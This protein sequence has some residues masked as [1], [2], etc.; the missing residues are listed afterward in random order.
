MVNAVTFHQLNKVP[1]AVALER[2]F[3]E[4]RIGG[5][6]V[7]RGG[8]QVGEIAATAAGH[9]DFLARLVGVIQ[10]QHPMA[11]I[12]SRGGTHQSGRT[13]ADHHNIHLCNCCHTTS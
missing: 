13:G 7:F 9:E 10:H 1:G 3:A 12:G 11:L 4:M 5:D 2:R 6:E 8:I